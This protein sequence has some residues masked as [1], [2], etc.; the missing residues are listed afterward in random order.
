MTHSNEEDKW[1]KAIQNLFANGRL[2]SHQ[3]V[4]YSRNSQEDSEDNGMCGC[5]RPIRNH[6]FDGSCPEERPRP[7]DWN[8]L[9]HA[10]KL[11]QLIYYSTVSRKVGSSSNNS[12]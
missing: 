12:A 3:C 9:A 6:S 10:R 1:T 5:Q 4:L 2:S 11:K 7:E 8:L